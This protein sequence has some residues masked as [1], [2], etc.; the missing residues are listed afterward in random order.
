MSCLCCAF[1]VAIISFRRFVVRVLFLGARCCGVV[2]GWCFHKS[3]LASAFVSLAWFR[4]LVLGFG[5]FG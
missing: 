3:C 5:P 4:T 2:R 1:E